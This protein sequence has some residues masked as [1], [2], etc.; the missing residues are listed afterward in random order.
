M[1]E[2][3]G[4]ESKAP[5]RPAIALAAI[6]AGACAAPPY[7][8][9]AIAAA[10]GAPQRCVSIDSAGSLRV[11]DRATI[12]FASGSTRWVNRLKMQCAGVTSFDIPVM[13]PSGSQYCSGDLVRTIDQ[14]TGIPGPACV[15]GDFVPYRR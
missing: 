10:A 9:P 14:R 15:L 4:I 1:K 3:V 8:A 12:T 11:V 7:E 13:E 5:K 2:A 6:L